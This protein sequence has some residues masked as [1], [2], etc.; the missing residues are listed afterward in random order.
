[1][2]K[3]VNWLYR[4]PRVLLLPRLRVRRAPDEAAIAWAI[5]L[6]SGGLATMNG[7]DVMEFFRGYVE[8]P[9]D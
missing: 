7:V 3:I 9:D 4:D 8:S 2:V 5:G 1:M 6:L